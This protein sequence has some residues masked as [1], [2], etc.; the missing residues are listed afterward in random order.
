MVGQISSTLTITIKKQAEN[1]TIEASGTKRSFIKK[2][3]KIA[4]LEK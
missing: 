4:T 2:I 1:Y 3:L